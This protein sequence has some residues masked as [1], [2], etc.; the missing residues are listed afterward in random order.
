MDA[1]TTPARSRMKP[2]GLLPFARLVWASIFIAQFATAS[3]LKL[4]TGAILTGTPLARTETSVTVE[5]KN[6]IQVVLEAAQLD[7]ESWAE[8]SKTTPEAKPTPRATPPRAAISERP[9]EIKWLDTGA[10]AQS[11]T[12]SRVATALRRLEKQGATQLNIRSEQIADAFE[13]NAIA[14]TE[15]WRGKPMAVTGTI[16]IMSIDVWGTPYIVLE[17]GVRKYLTDKKEIESIKQARTGQTIT[18]HGIFR[19]KS[20]LAIQRFDLE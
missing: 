11:S 10:N 9:A 16:S 18:L 2:R 6:G 15:R 7:P 5:T 3:E 8:I 4:S 17:G 14:A 13:A 1:T 20:A 12:E 19:G